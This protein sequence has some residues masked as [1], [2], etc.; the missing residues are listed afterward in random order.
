MKYEPFGWHH[1]EDQFFLS[2]QFRRALGET[3]E[4]GGAVS[5]CFQAASRMKPSSNR[6]KMPKLAS[7]RRTAF[8]S[9]A[10]NTGVRSP[11]EALMTC[12]TSAVG[13][14]T[15]LLAAALTPW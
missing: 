8:S 9:I 1:W 10:S 15:A 2:Y 11:G 12:S 6:H 3:Q 5:E 7:H 4:G 14:R 13:T